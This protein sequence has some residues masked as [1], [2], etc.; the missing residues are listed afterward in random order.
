MYVHGWHGHPEIGKK[1]LAMETVRNV[2]ILIFLGV[3]RIVRTYKISVQHELKALK[4]SICSINGKHWANF[5]YAE[6]ISIDQNSA[7]VRGFE[8]AYVGCVSI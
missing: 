7:G 1:V 2:P 4:I 5:T 8:S 6:P 3:L